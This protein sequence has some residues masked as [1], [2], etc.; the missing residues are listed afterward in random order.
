MY[1]YAG[2][3]HIHSS[4][5]DGSLEIVDIAAKAARVG[6][7]FIIITD[8]YTL[9]ALYDGKEGYQGTVLVLIGMEANESKN[10]Y[11]CLDIDK[12]VKN[13]NENPQ[14][15]IDE[16]NMQHG[17]GIIAH[18]FE[19]GTPLFVDGISFPWKDW[20]VHGFQG[21]EIWN[22]TSQWKDHITSAFQGILLAF[23][24][25]VAMQGPCPQALAR[26]DEYQ[27]RGE[28][29]FAVGGSDAHGYNM[30]LG[31]LDL[32]VSPYETSFKCINIHVLTEL[33]LS[34]ELESDRE[35]LYAAIRKG[36]LWIGYDYFLN[37]RGF[38]FFI[39]D[40]EKKFQM[41]DSVLSSQ[42]LEIRVLTPE[43]AR[44]RLMKNGKEWRV[45]SGKK[46]VFA[47]IDPGVYRIEVYHRYLLGYRSWIFSNSIWVE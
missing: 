43:T 13:N 36:S 33:P 31:M 41:G 19:K 10:H 27:S 20:N 9:Q 38:R 22:F 14:V 5:S 30:R 4:Y 8:H 34:G 47:N 39:R 12:E 44:V 26:M 37:S 28:K 17:I 40:K 42:H 18:P 15:V 3:M 45:S 46:H 2:N 7:D 35:I 24:P 21:I 25:H 16:V 32:Q 6:L 23:C 29:I 1:E 11:L